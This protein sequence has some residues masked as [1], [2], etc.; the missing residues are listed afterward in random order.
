MVITAPEVKLVQTFKLYFTQPQKLDD[1][2]D[3]IDRFGLF[4]LVLVIIFLKL[5]QTQ[6]KVRR[7]MGGLRGLLTLH[8]FSA[9][10]S[11]LASKLQILS[12]ED[13]VTHILW[14]EPK[15]QGVVAHYTTTMSYKVEGG[16]SMPMDL[17]TSVRLVLKIQELSIKLFN[18]ADMI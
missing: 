2:D 14:V 8:L 11:V 17:E 18:E 6:A 12:N 5:G 4:V 3:K 9:L 16:A 10:L 1:F 7:L 15:P 13:S